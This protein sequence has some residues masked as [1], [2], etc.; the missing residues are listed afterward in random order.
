MK[1]KKSNLL[2]MDRRQVLAQ[3]ASFGMAAATSQIPIAPAIAQGKRRDLRVG[4]W[5]GDFGNLSPAIRWT[6]P[7]ALVMNHIFDGL[8]RVDY[9]SRTV[10][11]WLAQEWANPNPLIW[12]LRLRE[13]VLWHGDYGE[14]TA[15]DVV[16]TWRHH[17]DTS[18]FMVG[19]ALFPIDTV[20]ADGK[21]VVEIKT[22]SPFGALPG[23]TLGYGGL[24]LS[25]VAH[26]EM[27]DQQY[28]SSPIGH[29][30]Y[31]LNE[32]RGNEVDLIRNENYWRPGFPK[33]ERINYRTIPDS[34]VRLQSLEAG[35]FDFISHPDTKDV[36]RVRGNPEFTLTSVPGWNW[37]YQGFNIIGA[38]TKASY[39]NKLVRQAI[40]YAIDRRAIVEE[41]YNGEAIPT[42]NQ[43]PPGYIGHQQPMLKYPERGDLNKARELI[44]RA[45]ISGYE[46]EVITSDKDWIRRELE[47]VAAMVSQIGI[48]YRIRNLDVGGFNNL[49]FSR[50]YEQLLEDITIVAPDPDSASWWFL[51]T[52]GSSSAYSN[53]KMDLMLDDARQDSDELARSVMYRDIASMTVEEC[54]MIMHCNVNY[55]RVFNSGLAGF[56]PGPQEYT[57]MLDEIYWK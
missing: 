56:T 45:G 11:P 22:K 36:S 41:I 44:A 27:G 19:S 8:V 54:P 39:L 31:I 25:R 29:G 43:I 1:L 34:G 55:V 4:I 51:H 28:S 52:S 3:T 10:V 47:L 40:S 13:G 32:M 46:V 48:N 38:D 21:Y 6:V 37:D 20:V 12:R 2:G 16:Y 5:G 15:D 30:P 57:E 7:A 49:W 9:A 17:F 14:F 42:D 23:A 35:E 33:L 26:L 53:P 24:I 50:N 18:S